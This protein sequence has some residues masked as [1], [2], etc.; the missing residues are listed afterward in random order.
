MTA[1]P[2]DVRPALEELQE[3]IDEALDRLRRRDRD[4]GVAENSASEPTHAR[5]VFRG[6]AVDVLETDDEILVR[7]DLPGLKP[8]EFKVDIVGDHVV[9]RAEHTHTDEWRTG[10][11]HRMERRTGSFVRFVALP[12][13]VDVD[14]AKATYENGLLS[15]V[16]PKTEASKA[17][18]VEVVA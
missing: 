12:T 6:P 5:P 1:L 17:R 3:R 16:L 11:I 2:L 15:L 14:R 10:R 8:D 18:Q 13:E 7:M 4:G 9:I